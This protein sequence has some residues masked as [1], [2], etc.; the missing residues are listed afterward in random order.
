[1]LNMLIDNIFVLFGARFFNKLLVFQ[2][3]RI[4]FLYIVVDLFQNAYEANFCHGL[5]KN[6]D[7]KLAQI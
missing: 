2:W 4:V 7:S 1:M 6:K 3:V 5:L